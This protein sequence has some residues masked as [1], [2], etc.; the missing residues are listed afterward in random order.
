V[1]LDRRSLDAEVVNDTLGVLLKYQDDISA[2]RAAKPP[3]SLDEI[4]SS[5]KR[6]VPA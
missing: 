5:L 6:F 2:I 4:H 1:E 3:A